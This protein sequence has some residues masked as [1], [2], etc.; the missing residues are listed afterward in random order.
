MESETITWGAK[1]VLYASITVYSIIKENRR[2]A[3]RNTYSL[4]SIVH[5]RNDGRRSDPYFVK[6]LPTDGAV[7]LVTENSEPHATPKTHRVLAVPDG[8]RLALFTAQR[9]GV[10]FLSSV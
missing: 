7:S 8:P 2:P 5:T 4:H 1:D 10:H 6:S 3:N 9:T